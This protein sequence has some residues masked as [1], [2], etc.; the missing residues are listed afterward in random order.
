M[1]PLRPRPRQ[2][3]RGFGARRAIQRGKAQVT[4]A[5][6]GM[7]CA[8][9]TGRV[10]R[11]LRAQPGVA[12]ATANLVTRAATEMTLWQATW[13]CGR[14]RRAWRRRCRVRG[15]RRPPWLESAPAHDPAGRR[16]PVLWRATRALR[17]CPDL[18][19]LRDRD[20]RG[21]WC[22]GFTIGFTALIDHAKRCR[23]AL[24]L[25][26]MTV[27]HGLAR[28]ARFFRKGMPALLACRSPDMNSLVAMGALW[29]LGPMVDAW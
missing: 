22:Q 16:G 13:I 7:T 6:E 21:I 20:G 24:S 3:G 15:F 12:E 29:R 5:V 10:E 18:A 8:A 28:D 23:M 26:L 9:C 27:V 2:D 14:W 25:F 4:L 1:T 19:G 17:R 11:V